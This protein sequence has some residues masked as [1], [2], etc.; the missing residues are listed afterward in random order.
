MLTI[1]MMSIILISLIQNVKLEM[2]M[3]SYSRQIVEN[4]YVTSSAITFIR[5]SL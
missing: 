3:W 2:G 5:V 1:S 4:D